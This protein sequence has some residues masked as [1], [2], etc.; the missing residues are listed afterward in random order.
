MVQVGR[1]LVRWLISSPGK[2][3]SDSLGRNRHNHNEVYMRALRKYIYH[4]THGPVGSSSI[5]YGNWCRLWECQDMSTIHCPRQENGFDCGVFTILSSALIAKGVPMSNMTYTQAV[6]DHVN[7]RD[8]IANIILDSIPPESTLLANWLRQ[9]STLTAPPAQSTAGQ[10][11]PAKRARTALTSDATCVAAPPAAPCRKV[12]KRKWK[13]AVCTPRKP[14]MQLDRKRIPLLLSQPDPVR[15]AELI[16]PP[17][18]RRKKV[19]GSSP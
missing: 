12:R 6:V 17:P 13:V 18:R 4:D 16:L 15:Q 8:R 9:P 3:S 14:A 1:R 10:R 19:Q 2:S 11:R 7:V 5:C